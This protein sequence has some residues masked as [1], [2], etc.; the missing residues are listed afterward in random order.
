M[1]YYQSGVRLSIKPLTGTCNLHLQPVLKPPYLPYKPPPTRSVSMSPNGHSY[2]GTNTYACRRHTGMQPHIGVGEE[3]TGLPGLATLPFDPTTP[4]RAIL[5]RLCA[6]PC[7]LS[8][9]LYFK[10]PAASMPRIGFLPARLRLRCV[11][12]HRSVSQ[13]PK[14]QLPDAFRMTS[15]SPE[16]QYPRQA[17]L[18]RQRHSEQ[19][20]A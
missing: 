9:C 13:M 12:L 6:K 10:A 3:A 17:H 8:C 1:L 4:T 14:D 18:V 7:L 19:Q 16:S 2:P 20:L 11:S 15:K 5:G